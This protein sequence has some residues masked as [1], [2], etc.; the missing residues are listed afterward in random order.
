MVCSKPEAEIAPLSAMNSLITRFAASSR[1]GSR[2]SND[3][4]VIRLRSLMPYACPRVVNAFA[5]RKAGA[6]KDGRYAVGIFLCPAAVVKSRGEAA[7]DRTFQNGCGIT[8]V[9]RLALVRWQHV[10]SNG[11]LGD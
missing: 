5:Y 11:S 8:A 3:G 2:Y 10:R 7:S 4:R 1:R 9:P 6:A